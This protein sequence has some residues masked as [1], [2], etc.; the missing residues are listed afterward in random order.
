MALVAMCFLEHQQIN[1][2]TDLSQSS[3]YVAT[4]S[5]VTIGIRIVQGWFLIRAV[6]ELECHV[7]E[8][9]KRVPGL[10]FLLYAVHRVSQ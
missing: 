5:L 9:H 7:P 3:C 4:Q 2:S 1:V 10:S 6:L 8:W